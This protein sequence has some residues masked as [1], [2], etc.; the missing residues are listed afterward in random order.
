MRELSDKP[1]T[2]V[3]TLTTAWASESDVK[4]DKMSFPPLAICVVL[5]SRP[6]ALISEVSLT[7]KDS[8]RES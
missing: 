6:M 2:W 5:F 1:E 4:N 8:G 7:S 3:E